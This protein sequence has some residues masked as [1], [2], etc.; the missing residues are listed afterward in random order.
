MLQAESCTGL[1]EGHQVPRVREGMEADQPVSDAQYATSCFEFLGT[2][3]DLVGDGQDKDMYPYP[4][5]DE[6]GDGSPCT[7]G[8]VIGMRGEDESGTRVLQSEYRHVASFGQ[9]R[10]DLGENG[11]QSSSAG[12]RRQM[13]YLLHSRGSGVVIA[14]VVSQKRIQPV[15]QP[16]WPLR[17]GGGWA[18]R[19]DQVR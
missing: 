7:K 12:L 15:P 8:F 5:G 1:E 10:N 13:C 16:V 14:L 3:V 4:L 19:P 9:R 18:G 2:H 11:E 17:E 6:T